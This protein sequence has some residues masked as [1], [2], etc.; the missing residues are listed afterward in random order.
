MAQLTKEDILEAISHMPLME[1]VD[2]VKLMEDK[3]GVQAQAAVAVAAPVAGGQAAVVTEEEKTAW[4][5]VMTGFGD[6]KIEVIK[7]IRQITG[8]SL[9]EAKDLVEKS[10]KEKVKVKEGAPKDEAEKILNQLKDAGASAE[11]V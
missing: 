5:V 10:A 6:R 4:D 11:L 2:L 9:K 1:V 8:L 3:F 7:Q